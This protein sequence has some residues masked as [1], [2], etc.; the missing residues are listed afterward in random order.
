MNEI[1]VSKNSYYIAISGLQKAIRR[2][3]AHAA[4]ACTFVA[5]K[6]D[7]HK[8]FRRLFTVL[9]EDC[10]RDGSAV[11]EVAK[12]A[13][14]HNDWESIEKFVRV[15]VASGKS[16][17]QGGLQFI[18]N[19]LDDF[20]DL[21]VVPREYEKIAR[22]NDLDELPD[23]PIAA[24]CQRYG[25]LDWEKQALFVFLTNQIDGF[26][27]PAFQPDED[28]I[29]A[30]IV[31]HNTIFYSALDL[32]TRYG[33]IAEGTWM[34]QNREALEGFGL[35]L[36]SRDSRR[37][38][39]FWHFSGLLKNKYEDNL[40]FFA[41]W[42]DWFRKNVTPEFLTGKMWEWLRSGP[43]EQM[44]ELRKWAFD[45]FCQDVKIEFDNALHGTPFAI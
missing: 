13:P 6:H 11:L 5:W 25:N 19:N 8:L 45:K 22:M 12:I 38:Y 41:G 27:E 31:W 14:R 24:F 43:A 1:K 36:E 30:D 17:E 21:A 37:L 32:H 15:M 2:G 16:R 39:M 9:F 10:G 20:A 4:V 40:G 23:H 3:N 34:K 26:N 29:G 44:F 28:L 35:D 18:F 42:V 33:A 7:K